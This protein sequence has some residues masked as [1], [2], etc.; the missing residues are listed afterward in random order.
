[1]VGNVHIGNNVVIAANAVV[2]RDVP[3]KCSVGGMP[4]RI[5]SDDSRGFFV[6]R[7][8]VVFGIIEKQ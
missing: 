1:M 3:D 2:T 4:A 6:G 7:N 8:N 5:L